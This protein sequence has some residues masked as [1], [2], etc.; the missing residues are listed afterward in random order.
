VTPWLKVD[1]FVL[2]LTE[3]VVDAPFT[4]WLNAAEVLPEIFAVPA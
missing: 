3:V 2:E 4:T 1:G